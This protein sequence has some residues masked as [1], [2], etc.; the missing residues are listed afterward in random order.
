MKSNK[1]LIGVVALVA[2]AAAYWFLLL[3]PKREEAAALSEQV[4]QKQ[5]EAAQAEST[6]ASYR[7]AQQTFRVNY[8]TIAR[9]GKAV[10]ADDDVR[11]L[12][13]QL[14]GA[15]ST[16]KSDFRSIAVRSFGMP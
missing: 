9:L 13:V 4:T 2:A 1:L 5:A 3:A 10:P 14:E 6:L 15:A 8:S 11:S 7:Q 16:S 12:V